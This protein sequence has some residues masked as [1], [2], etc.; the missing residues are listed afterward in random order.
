MDGM[1]M[2]RA[3]GSGTSF[4][5]QLTLGIIGLALTGWDWVQRRRGDY[6]W[7]LLFATA[8]W[9]AVELTAQLRGVRLIPER[10]LFGVALPLPISVLVQSAGEAGGLAIIGLFL[11]D[12]LLDPHTRTKAM[13]GVA[14]ACALL[15]ANAWIR[16]ATG[17]A[18][19]LG[20]VTSRRD[21]L[22]P[23]AFLV[24][25]TLLAIDIVFLLRWPAFRARAAAMALVLTVI[26]VAWNLGEITSG[27]RWIETAGPVPGTYRPASF[28]VQAGGFVFDATVEFALIYVAFLALPAMLGRIAARPVEPPVRHRMADAS[29]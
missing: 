11:S 19:H 29:A 2:V 10:T 27:G 4:A 21:M 23:G 20:A 3:F 7:V 13:G 17:D 22:V 9:A 14:I 16:V 28:W 18:A 26:G 12:R 24:F 6:A 8:T 1:Y 15:V 25:G 5:P